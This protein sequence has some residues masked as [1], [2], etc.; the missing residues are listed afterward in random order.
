VGLSER[1]DEPGVSNAPL[2]ADT[3]VMVIEIP[4][5]YPCIDSQPA[6]RFLTQ[7]EDGSE[8]PHPWHP[9]IRYFGSFA[10]RVCLN[11]PDSYMDLAWYVERTG[12]A[13]VKSRLD[14]TVDWSRQVSSRFDG[15]YDYGKRGWMSER[16]CHCEGLLTERY[17]DGSPA[18]TWFAL[19]PWA[20]GCILEGLT[21]AIWREGEGVDTGSDRKAN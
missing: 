17:P 20:C 9:N 13:Y 21:G 8:I 19:M 7:D 12:D 6:F 11:A 1:L 3:F 15:E 2:F 18:S 16:F 14:D 4:E 5:D 10:G